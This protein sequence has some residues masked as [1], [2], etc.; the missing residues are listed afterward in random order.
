MI[1]NLKIF[2]ISWRGQQDNAQRIVETLVKRELQ[3]RLVFSDPDPDFTPRVECPIERRPDHLFWG[4]KFRA[5]LSQIVDDESML[6]I[7]ADCD[8]EDWPT[9]ISRCDAVM[10][11]PIIGV[12]SPEIDGVRWSLERQTI[13]PLDDDLMAVGRTDGIVFAL[14]PGVI[15]RM[16]QANYDENTY[17]RGIEAMFVVAAYARGMIAVVDRSVRVTHPTASGYSIEQAHEQMVQFLKQL[18]PREKVQLQLLNQNMRANG[19]RFQMAQKTE[20]EVG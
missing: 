6:V 8:C 3:V 9:L 10:S 19:G 2:I 20:S 13:L 4:D 16:K 5:C 17:G 7:H 14:S 18:G 15:A 11:N 12:W 1:A